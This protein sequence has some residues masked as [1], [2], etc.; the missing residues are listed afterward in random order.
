[1]FA[2]L[3]VNF[4]LVNMF[5]E[6]IFMKVMARSTSKKSTGGHFHLINSV[7]KKG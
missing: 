1:M 5:F 7:Q 4:M 3:L 6:P 2:F